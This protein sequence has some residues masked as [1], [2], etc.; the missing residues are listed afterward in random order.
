MNYDEESI[1]LHRKFKGKL[2]TKVDVDIN[3]KDDLS[4]VYTPGVAAVCKEIEEKPDKIYELSSVGKTIAVISNGTAV[5]G[6]GNI[7][8]KAA[9]PVMEGKA[10][11]FKSLGG[12]NA[13]PI[14]VDI[15][16]PEEFIKFVKQIS[17]NYAGINLE[18]IKAPECFLI[19]KRLDEELDIPVFHDDQHGT[20]IVVYAGLKNALKIVKKEFSELKIVVSG[21]GA[22]GI[23]I[24]KLL[25]E[26]KPKELLMVDSKGIL[27]NK[28]VYGDLEFNKKIIG[29]NTSEEGNIHDAIKGADVFIGVSK[30]HILTRNDVRSMSSDPIIFAMANPEPEISVSE[31]LEGGARIVTNGRSD[32]K[33]QVNNLL[34]FPGLFAGV[35]SS[36]KK[37]SHEMKVKTAEIIASMV[38]DLE[39][40]QGKILPNPL[41][42][43]VHEK[44]K[45]V[46]SSL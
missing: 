24:A 21:A 2:S 28:R 22:A 29:Q 33:N 4:I 1:K 9:Y 6:L 20:A 19:E 45:E 44:I 25:L 12:V 18:D 43:K 13:Q 35:I 23:A 46:I 41:D 36:R 15:K 3:N 16:D 31:A 30:P 5:L 14:C 11:L 8:A 38:T 26:E 27:N 7:G 10:A 39:L 17:V 37:I 42:K 32:C 40:K 34:A